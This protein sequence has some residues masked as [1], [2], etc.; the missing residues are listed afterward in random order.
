MLLV[1]ATKL[2]LLVT[3]RED[4]NSDVYQPHEDLCRDE[5][6]DWVMYNVSHMTHSDPVCKVKRSLT[7]PLQILP[8]RMRQLLL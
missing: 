1:G 3:L 8:M 7:N 5:D 4:V 6:D 2:V